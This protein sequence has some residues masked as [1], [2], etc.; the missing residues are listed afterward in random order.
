MSS[1]IARILERFDSLNEGATTPSSLGHGLNQQ[2][3]KADQLPAL[4]KPKNISPTLSKKPYQKHPMDGKLVGGESAE[5][6]KSA[7]EEAMQEVEEDMIS[8]VKQGFADYLE[9]LEKQNKLDGH[10]VRKAKAELNIDDDPE[11]E[12]AEE[13][14]TSDPAA[15]EGPSDPGDTEVAHDVENQLATAAVVP[16][17]PVKT[18]AMEDGIAFECYG[19]DE[20][21]FEIRRGGRS[22][23]HRFDRL[24]HADMAV[25]LFQKRREAA[26]QDQDYIEER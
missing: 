21:G 5:P 7:L 14:A 10:L 6:T 15:A 25:R 8:K 24:D 22:L 26:Q 3:K 16:E 23:P 11:T 9:R 1:D 20:K 13:M 18:Y 2:Q 12:G 17:Q 19:D 4:F